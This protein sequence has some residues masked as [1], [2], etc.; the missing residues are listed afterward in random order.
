M[1]RIHNEIHGERDAEGLH[2]IRLT[3]ESVFGW[4]G[5]S[6]RK[7]ETQTIENGM[8]VDDGDAGDGAAVS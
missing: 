3:A 4:F 2:S 5:D 1:C 7:P 6:L 8:F